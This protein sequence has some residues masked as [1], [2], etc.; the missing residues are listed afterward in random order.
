EQLNP[1][2]NLGPPDPLD[3]VRSGS[4]GNPFLQPFTSNN[5]DAS[6]EYYFSRNGF[7]T[8]EYTDPVL[9]PVEV[10]APVNTRSGRIDGFE[11]QFQTFFDYE[12]VPRFFRNFG[13]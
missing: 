11:A 2:A 9:G 4:G 7:A 10:T 13:V 3:N 12:W 6:L 1:S 5:Y 8:I